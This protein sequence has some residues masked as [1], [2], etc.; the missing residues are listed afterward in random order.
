[1]FSAMIYGWSFNYEVGE[2]ARQLDEILELEL[3]GSIQ[4]GDPQLRVTHTEVRGT[5]LFVW[6]DYHLSDAQQRRMQMWRSGTFRNAQGLGFG[7]AFLPEYP[8]WLA[9]KEM[10][11]EDAARAAIRGIL[12][13]NERNRPRKA[14]GFI[15][16][17]SFPRFYIDA[18]RW[19]A[20]AR[21]RVQITEI[22]PF[23]V[24]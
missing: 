23:A 2:R 6:A 16:L 5:Q 11:L 10:A 13:A 9:V 1:F 15:S 19:A 7:P 20:S 24:H 8:G 14:V 18:G 21:F 22:I 12:R 4:F 17:A 3:L